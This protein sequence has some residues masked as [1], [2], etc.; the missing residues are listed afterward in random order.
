MFV[1]FCENVYGYQVSCLEKVERKLKLHID[2]PKIPTSPA[3]PTYDIN[4]SIDKNECYIDDAIELEHNEKISIA[5]PSNEITSILFA[6]RSVLPDFPEEIFNTFPNLL[7]VQMIFSGIEVL[8]EDDFLN[9]TNL[10]YLRL[11][12]NNIGI[13]SRTA[14]SNP[15]NLKTLMLIGNNIGKIEDY[16]FTKLKL[17]NELHLQMNN[18]ETLTANTF[19]GADNISI[20]YL[21]HNKI[22]NIEDGALYLIDL[23]ELYLQSNRLKNLSPDLLTGAQTLERIDLSGNELTTI[24]ETFS[25]CLNLSSLNL[26]DN[27]I[28]KIDWFEIANCPSLR[29]LSLK[30]NN[31]K[32]EPDEDDN[33]LEIDQ[34]KLNDA[35]RKSNLEYLNLSDNKLF[36][37]DFLKHLQALKNLRYLN[38]AN[39]E[40][41][42]IDDLNEIKK[43]Y[44]HFIQMDLY[45]VPLECGWLEKSLDTIHALDIHFKTITGARKNQLKEIDGIVCTQTEP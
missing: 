17:L 28:Q 41:I 35:H 29:L 8:E 5:N 24:G 10:E 7:K 27:Q 40:L 6:H 16:S 22:V 21:N 4:I 19:S 1:I 14:F 3:P 25:K 34:V 2:D 12:R 11:E 38:L 15:I 39:N 43:W 30:N 45:N 32:I 37:L 42:G 18:L 26:D 20:L 33:E 31:V 13:I 9:A 23:K 44:P 36:R